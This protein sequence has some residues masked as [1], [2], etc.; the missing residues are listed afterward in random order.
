MNIPSNNPNCNATITIRGSYGELTVDGHTGRVL[1]Y[2]A[3][4]QDPDY[5]D[6]LRVNLKEY[7]RTYGVVHAD[8]DIL[9]IGFITDAGMHVAP[10]LEWRKEVQ[11]YINEY[12]K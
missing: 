12:S 6:I 7:R 5:S 2:D 8:I 1:N 9:D 10:D 3:Q 11:E 4:D